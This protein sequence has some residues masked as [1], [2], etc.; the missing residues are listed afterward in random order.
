MPARPLRADAQR[1]RDR[2]LTVAAEA[3]TER[4]VDASLEEIAR[5]AGVGVGTLYRRFPSRDALIEAVYRREVERLC[6]SATELLETLPPDAA[7]AEWMQRFVR[8][9]T[10][11]RGLGQALKSVIEA[12]SE[13]FTYTHQLVTDAMTSL[14]AAAVETGSVRRDVEPHDVLKAMSGVCLMNERSGGQDP[15]QACRVTRL[16]MDG[17]RYGAPAA[18]AEL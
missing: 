12:D 16:L 5:R 9:V 7:L 8:Y 3:F 1:N 14:L 13:L 6:A 10:M 18:K 11:K 2:L 4:G 17:L 15:D